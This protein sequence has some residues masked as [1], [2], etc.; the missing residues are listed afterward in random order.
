[1]RQCEVVD[2]SRQASVGSK[3]L[4]RRPRATGVF[5][6]ALLLALGSVLIAS[7]ARADEPGETAEG[8]LLVQQAL[9]HLAHGEAGEG[10]DDAM[11]KIED[12][13]SVEDQ[14]GVN[15]ALVEEA[16]AALMAGQ[17][18]QAQA[19]LQESISE[20]ISQ[21]ETATGEETGTTVVL[22]V[23]PGRAGL[24]G[25]DWGLLLA[26][27]L[28]LVVGAGLAWRYRPE[29]TVDELRHRLGPP[30]SGPDAMRQDQPRVEAP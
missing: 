15:V 20:A 25:L 12:A 3:R 2:R 10:M 24:T 6:I 14:A 11:E 13:L 21:L 23:L 29:D 4:A 5:M 22:G 28:L 16:Q 26:S 7:P 27:V 8:Y 30:G 17:I 18:G 19:L 9:G 1:M